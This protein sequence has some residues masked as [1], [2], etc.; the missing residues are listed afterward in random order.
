MGIQ[1]DA[2]ELLAFIYKDKTEK[3][4]ICQVDRIA[5]ETGWDE[6][7]IFAGLQYLKDKG[8]I[9]ADSIGGFGI[10][11]MDFTINDITA[12]GI[13]IIENRSEF[14]TTFGFEI[15][16]GLVKFSWTKEE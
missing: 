13:D 15:N 7:R 6:A 5:S 2:G 4:E 14:K 12:N 9:D 16:L 1:N 10:R 8:L 3:S 11:V